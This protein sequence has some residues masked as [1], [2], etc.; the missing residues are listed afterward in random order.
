MIN[1]DLFD[2]LRTFKRLIIDIAIKI[3][4]RMRFSINSLNGSSREI[5]LLYEYSEY[6]LPNQNFCNLISEIYKQYNTFDMSY[7]ISKI[8]SESKNEK[9]WDTYFLRKI[10][11]HYRLLPLII[12]L[13]NAKKVIEIGTY[14][15][16]SS[17][18]II[19]NSTASL[20]TFDIIKWDNFKSTYFND[21]DFNND[22]LRQLIADLSLDREFEKYSIDLLDA[23][24]IFIDG[25]KDYKFEKNFLG[26]LF[27]L[28]RE[29]PDREVFI[30]MDDVKRSTMANI[31]KS[32]NYP[33]CILDMVG[34]WSG[35]GLIYLSHKI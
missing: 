9:V 25:P 31:W 27:R 17:K 16:A 28:Y 3:L 12:N 14:R 4:N 5:S 21:D 33:K 13:I 18:S 30:L 26:K 7:K 23:D 2:I 34:H 8:N 29:N 35:S 32:I 19:N 15:G 22:S 6:N 20:I 10:G 24:F 11:E 1:K